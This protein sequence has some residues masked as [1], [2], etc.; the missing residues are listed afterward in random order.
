MRPVATLILA[1]LAIQPALAQDSASTAL[2]RA[3]VEAAI[4]RA[5]NKE[6]V[7]EV[8]PGRINVRG[9]GFIVRLEGP[10]NR[11]EA[12]ARQQLKKYLPV[13]ADSIPEELLS[14]ILKI[15]ASPLTQ[16][17]TF[18]GGDV[19]TPHATHAVLYLVLDGIERIVQPTKTETFD[20]EVR[21]M[22][23]KK[24]NAKSY[25]VR[26]IRASFPYSDLPSGGFEVRIVTD[27][28]EFTYEVD[29]KKRARLH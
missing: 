2:S 16:V 12:Y 17:T 1:M 24:G 23:D 14:P 26:G 7:V 5:R 19:I 4:E 28:R 21:G 20:V 9:T 3:D 25:T 22:E 15:V 11:I 6:D 18:A 10:A 13:T 29:A 8:K 27:G